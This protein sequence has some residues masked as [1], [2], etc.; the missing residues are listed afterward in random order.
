MKQLLHQ[1]DDLSRRQFINC[2]AQTFL[3]VTVWG[4]AQGLRGQEAPV[5]AG[6]STGRHTAKSCIYLY[7]SGGMTHLDTFDP[8][9]GTEQGG[10][11]RAIRTKA[12]DVF[13]SEF[14]PNLAYR[15]D[16][17]ALVRSLKTNQGAHE[18]GNY[19]MH[20]SYAPRNTIRH[21]GMGPWMTMLRGRFN[22]TLPGSVVIG[23]GRSSGA[24]FFPPQHMPLILGSA[25]EG[26]KNS[27][28]SKEVNESEF[29]RRLSLAEAVDR[30]F[31]ST[32]NQK[33]VV[34]YSDMYKDA[35]KL[36]KS[37]D[38][39]AFD[40]N[41]EPADVKEAYGDNGFGQGILL[42]RR[43]VENNVRFVEVQLGGWD[44]HNN[45]F[46]AVADKAAT[47]D[48]ALGTLIGDLDQRG[49]L[50]ETLIV[51]ATEFGRTPRINQNDGRDHWP[52]AF[53]GIIAGGGIRGG[54][55]YG[56]TDE[57][58]SRVAENPVQVPDFN[59]TIATALGLPVGH[60]LYSPSGRPFKVADNGTP[61]TDIVG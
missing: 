39:K 16:K 43:L 30:E 25:R 61:I 54:Q 2:A 56:K 45:N 44:T 1:A 10:P 26:L 58:G 32:Y 7:M 22:R 50:D 35:V 51:L 27:V 60:T 23:G 9:P 20:T 8:K 4:H 24:G 18:Q 6:A 14:F 13:L 48:R 34:A 17:V 38:L 36:M 53:S 47:L 12:D 41:R 15:M 57:S 42:A 28:R 33:K 49:L 59:A 46:T 37:E 11:V 40:I 19:Y 29:N 3:G 55:A 52:R 31:V 5:Q 21:P